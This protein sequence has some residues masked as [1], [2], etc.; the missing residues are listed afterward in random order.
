LFSNDFRAYDR[1]AQLYVQLAGRAGRASKPGEVL[2]QPHHPEHALLQ[3]LLSKGY[4]SFAEHALIERN[5][6]ML[7]PFSYLVLFRA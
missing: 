2:L 3:S 6:A 4:G 1:L 7:P 5:Q